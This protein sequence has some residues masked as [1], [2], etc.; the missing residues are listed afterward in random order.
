MEIFLFYG[1]IIILDVLS[2]SYRADVLQI[3][4]N[5]FTDTIKISIVYILLTYAVSNLGGYGFIIGFTNLLMLS[6]IRWI[7]HDL[8]L[9]IVRDK[10]LDY[11]GSGEN[12]SLLDQWLAKRPKWNQFTLKGIALLTT[13]LISI[14]MRTL[15]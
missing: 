9:N 11:L 4:I 7:L 14:L 1:I 2:D 15:L 12:A 13:I 10:P 8:L 6:S 3:Q 5:H